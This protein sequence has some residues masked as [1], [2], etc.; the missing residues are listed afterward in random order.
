MHPPSSR[1]PLSPNSSIS[2][3]RDNYTTSTP[4]LRAF[5]SPHGRTVEHLGSS[6]T[7][8][9]QLDTPRS[10]Q[11]YYPVSSPS[12]IT[13]YSSATLAYSMSSE[14]RP[15]DTPP[16]DT[17][18]NLC[19]LVC[20][21]QVITPQIESKIEKGFFLSADGC[22]TCYRRNYFSVQCSFTLSPHH[23]TQNRPLYIIHDNQRVQVQAMSMTLSAAVD[24]QAGKSI[25]LV[26]HTP[27]RDK[28]P[29]LQ[30][31][32]E[33][34]YPTLPGR[35]AHQHS[36]ANGYPYGLQQL[37]HPGSIAIQQPLLPHQHS[38]QDSPSSFG[39][40]HGGHT[41]MQHQHTFERIQ[42]KSATANNGKRRAQQQ[43]YHLI[44]ELHV[45]VRRP[46]ES[47]PKWV[48]VAQKARPH[49]ASNS[50]G[51]SGAAG[52]SGLGGPGYSTVGSG[53]ST[54]GYSTGLSLG[55]ATGMG[56]YRSTQYSVDPSPVGSHSIS[57]NSSLNGLHLDNMTT[58][59][60]S[61]SD[62]DNNKVISGFHG[63]TYHPGPL[64]ELPPVSK[65]LESDRRVKDEHSSNFDPSTLPIPLATG[66][67]GRF[68]ALDSSR[69]YYIPDM[70]TY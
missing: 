8:Y 33:K 19:D 48:K 59:H 12:S 41:T 47:E 53:S 26:Q 68:Q 31:R 60:S 58:E 57:S 29:Q 34:V 6:R 49:S 2:T 22:W 24:G 45:D 62:D 27:K 66:Y 61:S 55:G 67:C 1:T 23:V 17:Q 11:S 4:G 39:S 64:Y 32:N 37:S 20:E 9:A 16:F 40:S 69:G 5:S 18:V 30:V 35:P 7:S 63:Y 10:V 25:D 38:D 46:T 21:G 44:V 51:P 13:D 36:D 65:V 50:R 28:G 14:S 52:G 3:I 42:F 54:R 70:N 56:S 43:Y 15:Q